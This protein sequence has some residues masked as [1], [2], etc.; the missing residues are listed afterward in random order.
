MGLYDTPAAIEYV[1]SESGSSK[2][3]YVG[4]SMGTT[5]FFIA[6]DRHPSLQEK[7]EKMV[8][9]APAAYLSHTRSPARYFA[10]ASSWF[11]VRIK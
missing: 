5:A 9:L 11:F 1:L 8:A 7:V 10:P 3:S 4:H 6:M 2:L